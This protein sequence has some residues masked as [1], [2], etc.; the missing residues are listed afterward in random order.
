[1]NVKGVA[2]SNQEAIEKL[3][4][5]VK[6]VR[7]AMMTTVEADGSL[8]S[9]PMYTQ[10]ADSFNGELWFFTKDDSGKVREIMQDAHINLAY[11]EPDDGRYVSVSGRAQVID[12][13]AKEKE[14]WNPSLKAWFD[15]LDDPKMTLIRVDADEAEYWEGSGNTVVQLFKMAQA[16]I[17]GERDD[18]ENQKV[19]L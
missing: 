4:E 8:H 1:M 2:M 17:T 19:K 11:A 10:E 15:G 14:L 18:G 12:D 16:A 5:K 9:R 7:I 6:D 3:W 13:K